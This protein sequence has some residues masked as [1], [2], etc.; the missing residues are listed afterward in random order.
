MRSTYSR[1]IVLGCSEERTEVFSSIVVLDAS[2]RKE[3]EL[4]PDQSSYFISRLIPDYTSVSN[5]S[6]A[7]YALLSY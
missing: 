5:S 3:K 7:L 2:V 6:S 1:E 4:L